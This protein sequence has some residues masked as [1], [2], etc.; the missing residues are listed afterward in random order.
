VTD[1]LLDR[2]PPF[3]GA[4]RL[5]PG[6][7]LHQSVIV[8]ESRN[9]GNRRHGIGRRA[10]LRLTGSPLADAGVQCQARRCG[11][12][13]SVWRVSATTRLGSCC[14]TLGQDAL[15]V[16]SDCHPGIKLSNGAQRRQHRRH[17]Q[18]GLHQ[19]LAAFFANQ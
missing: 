17:V 14:G 19:P 18:I 1:D 11:S 10:A 12:A 2:N 6:L 4:V 7:I 3:A 9:R 16:V 13:G 15:P 8:S 5:I